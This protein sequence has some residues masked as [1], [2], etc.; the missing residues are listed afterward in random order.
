MASHNAGGSTKNHTNQRPKYR[1]VKKFGGEKVLAGNIIIRQV[2]NKFYC[3]ENTG[4]GRD[5]TIFAKKDGVVTFR[6]GWK[7]RTYVSIEQ[8]Q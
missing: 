6:T 8:T 5:F 4:I 3:G 1:G 2:G 7:N